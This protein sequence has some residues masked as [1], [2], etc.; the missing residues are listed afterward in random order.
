MIS[1][2][3]LNQLN[4]YFSFQPVEAAYLFGSEASGKANHLS[5][6][7]VAVL[8]TEK[9]NQKQRNDLRLAMIGDV[10][11]ILQRN[12]AEVVDLKELPLSFNYQAIAPKKMLYLRPGGQTAAYEARVIKL[13]LDIQPKLRLIARRQLEIIAKKGLND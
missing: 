3:K 13:Y 6:V 8:F 11:H 10:G 1:Q 7:D 2:A 12:D 4:R 9:L 5:D